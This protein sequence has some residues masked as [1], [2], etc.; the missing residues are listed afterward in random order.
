[1][2]TINLDFKYMESLEICRDDLI[3]QIKAVE[4]EKDKENSISMLN[5]VSLT[6]L[7][8]KK[9]SEESELITT[10]LR[11][12]QELKTREQA[13]KT[14]P[15]GWKNVRPIGMLTLETPSQYGLL[16]QSLNWPASGYTFLPKEQKKSSRP[17]EEKNKSS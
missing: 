1:M 16:S 12:N 3:S 17:N 6:K 10:L 9:G 8:K 4:I 15:R 7:L 14:E 5:P 2:R 11:E 13:Q